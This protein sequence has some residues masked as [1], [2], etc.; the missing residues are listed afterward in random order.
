M[1]RLDGTTNLMDMSWSKIQELVMDREAWCAAVQGVTELDTNERLN[2]L[3]EG[4]PEK[5]W[6]LGGKYCIISNPFRYSGLNPPG[7][8]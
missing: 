2:T 5:S 4:Q 6:T 1:R 8:L 3:L 7:F